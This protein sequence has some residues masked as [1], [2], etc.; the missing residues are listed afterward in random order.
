MSETDNKIIYTFQGI[1]TLSQIEKIHINNAIAYS[2]GNKIEAAK[3]L[4]ISV[5][6]LYNKINQYKKEDNSVTGEP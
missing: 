4:G 1:V 2:N 3:I 5:K 6:T